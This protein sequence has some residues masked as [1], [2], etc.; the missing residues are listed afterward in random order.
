MIMCRNNLNPL[1][2]F[3]SKNMLIINISMIK[4]KEN[5][6]SFSTIL[7][8]RFSYFPNSLSIIYNNR[9]PINFERYP[10]EVEV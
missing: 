3:S 2:F 7:P 8:H 6:F 1:K 5:K 9:P 4:N 10:V